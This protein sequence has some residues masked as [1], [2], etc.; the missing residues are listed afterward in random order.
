MQCMNCGKKKAT[1]IKVYENGAVHVCEDHVSDL[2]DTNTDNYSPR[3][4]RKYLSHPHKV[5]YT[6]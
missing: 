5:M 6:K 2:I 3:R 4:Y 1:R